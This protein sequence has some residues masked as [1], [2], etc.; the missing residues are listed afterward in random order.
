MIEIHWFKCESFQNKIV[1]ILKVIQYRK[2]GI[3][4]EIE[5][6]T[7]IRILHFHQ[8]PRILVIDFH[9]INSLRKLA[10]IQ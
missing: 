10:Y 2:G 3:E 4:I 9:Q 6:E 5:I 7:E 8:F 1:T